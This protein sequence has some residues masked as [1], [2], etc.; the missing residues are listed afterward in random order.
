MSSLG[1]RSVRR[2]APSSRAIGDAATGSSP[3][4]GTVLG[5]TVSFDAVVAADP[6]IGRTRDEL[7]PIAVEGEDATGE[8]T[9]ERPAI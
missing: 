4:V 9:G 8:P 1:E 5:A 7:H 6:V 2:F 3:F